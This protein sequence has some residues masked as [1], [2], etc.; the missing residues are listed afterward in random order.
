MPS[1]YCAQL[2]RKPLI[3]F[4]E[5]C[6]L[7]CEMAHKNMYIRDDSTAQKRGRTEYGQG[8]FHPTPAQPRAYQAVSNVK[9]NPPCN[10]LFIGNLSEGTSETE[11]NVLFG[12]QPGFRQLKLI[13]SAKSTTC[14]VEF[15]SV[16]SAMAVHQNQQVQT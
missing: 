6:S 4:D 12:A 7:R 14:F 11:L 3:R 2:N 9:D 15:D 8:M 5:G 10:T 16:A 13:R 1:E